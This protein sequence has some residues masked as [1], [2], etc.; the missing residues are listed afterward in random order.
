MAIYNR[1][2]IHRRGLNNRTKRDIAWFVYAWTLDTVI[3][4]RRLFKPSLALATLKE[5]SGR[6][7]AAFDLL[8]RR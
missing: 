1:Y 2:E 8:I 5:L 6:A 3:L 7:K 4:G